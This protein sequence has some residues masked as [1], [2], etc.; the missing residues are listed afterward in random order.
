MDERY[1]RINA[2]AVKYRI[3]AFVST[4]A[5][6]IETYRGEA[7]G[8]LAYAITED[9][10]ALP[11]RFRAM[12]APISDN[13]S[14]VL[15]PYTALEN[16]WAWNRIY[17]EVG[18][19]RHHSIEWQEDSSIPQPYLWLYPAPA[20]ERIFDIPYYAWPPEITASGDEFFIPLEA[21]ASLRAIM[22]GLLF[23]E[24]GNLQKA[25]TQL[26]HAK[27]MALSHLGSFRAS[28]EPGRM[29][30]WNAATDPSDGNSRDDSIVTLKAGEPSHT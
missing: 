12:A 6:T 11:A 2:E 7:A 23:R 29:D 24:Q 1:M 8:T 3:T 19:P 28:L 20:D 21:H 17:K 22:L 16:I 10:L 25:E 13:T 5:L 26:A 4:T 27:A 15:P 30:E 14:Y 18:V 9:R